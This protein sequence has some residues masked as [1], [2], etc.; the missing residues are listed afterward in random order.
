MTDS[1]L[2]IR[3]CDGPGYNEFKS[4]FQ[5]SAASTR[6]F[7]TRHRKR[8]KKRL[9]AGDHGC[10]SRL[11]YGAMICTLAKAQIMTTARRLPQKRYANATQPLPRTR[12]QAQK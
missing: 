8:A 7:R 10:D 3:E 11:V 4:D 9:P 12:R 5:Q 6:S 2:I 1:K